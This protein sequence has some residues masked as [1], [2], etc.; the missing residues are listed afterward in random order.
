[1]AIYYRPFL[2]EYL[3]AF[4]DGTLAMEIGLF[5]KGT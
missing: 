4:I 5:T 2:F 3:K 1:M